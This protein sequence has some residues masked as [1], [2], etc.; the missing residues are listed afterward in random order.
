MLK[1]KKKIILNHFYVKNALKKLFDC[2]ICITL[3]NDSNFRMVK[4]I[5]DEIFFIVIII[6]TINTKVFMI[7]FLFFN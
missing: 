6:S 4:V 3:K 7:L 2:S 1:K 5:F